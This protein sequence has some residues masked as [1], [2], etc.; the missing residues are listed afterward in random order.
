M[1]KW[2][3]LVVGIYKMLVSLFKFMKIHFIRINREKIAINLLPA[4]SNFELGFYV[5]YLK[6]NKSLATFEKY[7]YML[8]ILLFY[9]FN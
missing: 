8:K 4:K 6:W 9:E 2:E 7:F 1:Q 5:K 3:I